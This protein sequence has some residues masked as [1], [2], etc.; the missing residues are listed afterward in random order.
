MSFTSWDQS[1]K[2]YR[3]VSNFTQ[4]QL[5]G[6]NELIREFNVPALQSTISFIVWEWEKS[7]F[8]LMNC[9]ALNSPSKRSSGPVSDLKLFI[10]IF[11]SLCLFSLF[12]KELEG[13]PSEEKKGSRWTALTTL[14]AAWFL[15]AAAFYHCSWSLKAEL[16]QWLLRTSGFRLPYYFDQ[17]EIP[18]FLE[19]S[20][21]PN[22]VYI[23]EQKIWGFVDRG[24][25]LFWRQSASS[26]YA[27]FPS[28]SYPVQAEVRDA[29]QALLVPAVELTCQTWKSQGHL[30]KCLR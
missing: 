20:K 30:S 6:G 3:A 29:I 2:S 18:S 22:S 1:R 11:F 9:H 23:S 25:C 8:G 4:K 13:H 7:V 15:W 12:N 10:R 16:D 19:V 28:G 21:L 5:L 27:H 14:T 24:C 26:S 17:V